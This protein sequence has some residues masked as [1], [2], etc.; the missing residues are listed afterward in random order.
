MPAT[1]EPGLGMTEESPALPTDMSTWKARYRQELMTNGLG[2]PLAHQLRL[3]HLQ[4]QILLALRA[5]RPDA[6]LPAR[7]TQA[8]LA[9]IVECNPDTVWRARTVFR[10]RGL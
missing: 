5:Y 9:D 8:M 1:G 7:P 3:T 10:V 6:T 4:A 2:Y